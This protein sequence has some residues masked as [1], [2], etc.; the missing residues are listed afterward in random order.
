MAVWSL[1]SLTTF[2]WAQNV[3]GILPPRSYL[4]L[5]PSIFAALN[6]HTGKNDSDD[7]R[8]LSEVTK[9]LRPLEG[10]RREQ[11]KALEG[12]FLVKCVGVFDT[13]RPPF[14]LLYVALRLTD[15]ILPQV[16]T[17]GRPTSLRLDPPSPSS[18]SPRFNSFG[19]D[20]SILEPIV[21]NAFQALA[22]DERRIDF[23]PVL[24]N[25]YGAVG[26]GKGGQ[27][28]IPGQRLLQVWF[29]GA[30]AGESRRYRSSLRQ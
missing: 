12:K 9:L 7:H 20:E 8:A 16:A 30:H 13:V 2:P 27:G 14:P 11:V 26:D 1:E 21:E 17:R 18:T 4:H 6:S 24:W 22:I 29:P 5:F 3:I 23:R 10:F 28:G 15:P 19:F 25:R